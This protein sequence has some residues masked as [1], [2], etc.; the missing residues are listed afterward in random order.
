MREHEQA[1]E[2]EQGVHAES[3][4]ADERY[5]VGAEI[6]VINEDM[7]HDA[8]SGILDRSGTVIS[9]VREKN[10]SLYYVAVYVVLAKFKAY[11]PMVVVKGTPT[12]FCIYGDEVQ[13]T[14]DYSEWYI[15]SHPHPEH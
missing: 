14:R 8:N 6:G 1:G 15:W 4:V 12:S 2:T 9:C 3:V 13:Q 7:H 11:S 10:D 5:T